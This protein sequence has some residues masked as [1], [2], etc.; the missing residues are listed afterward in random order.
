MASVTIYKDSEQ[1]QPRLLVDGIAT[2]VEVRDLPRNPARPYFASVSNEATVRSISDV[3]VGSIL[4]CLDSLR[5]Y[6]YDGSLLVTNDWSHASIVIDGD[7]WCVENG[8]NVRIEVQFD[9]EE[10]A[11]PYSIRAYAQGLLDLVTTLGSS[12]RY[13][14][15]KG[16]YANSDEDDDELGEDYLNGFGIVAL[17]EQE[18]TIAK[19]L[20]ELPQRLQNY[21]RQVEIELLQSQPGAVSRVFSFPDSLR[22]SCEQYLVYFGQFLSDLGIQATTELK[23]EASRVLFRVVPNDKNEALEAIQQALDTYLRIPGSPS[24]DAAMAN[25]SEIAVLQLNATVSHLRAQFLLAAAVAQAKD[26]TISAQQAEI[27]NLRGAVDLTRYARTLPSSSDSEQLV[28]DLV[29]VKKLEYKGFEFNFPE[30]L[31]RLKR[32]LK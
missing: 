27:G 26:A 10:W 31:R 25:Y 30:I 11:R 18:T 6:F 16:Y 12:D 28:G 13:W 24:S 15:A 21:F 3:S 9:W 14:P 5:I 4:T 17:V 20:V 32:K 29:S 7:Q 22:A 19:L 2:D 8:N 23:E 1:K